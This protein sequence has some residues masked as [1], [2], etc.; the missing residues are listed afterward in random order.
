MYTATNT[1]ARS[2]KRGRKKKGVRTDSDEIWC[3][4]RHTSLRTGGRITTT[5]L[6][7]TICRLREAQTEDNVHS[8]LVSGAGKQK[9]TRGCPSSAHQGLFTLEQQHLPPFVSVELSLFGN[10]LPVRTSPLSNKHDRMFPTKMQKN[11]V[12]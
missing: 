6:H 7:E 9:E 3:C 11:S 5:Q 12:Q 10:A 1:R 8:V 2:G 4:R